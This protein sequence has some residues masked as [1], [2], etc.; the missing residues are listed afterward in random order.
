MSSDTPRSASPAP[1][2]SPAPQPTPRARS[3]RHAHL[4]VTRLDPW[5]VMKNALMLAIALGIVMLVAVALLW[6][7]LS[8]SGTLAAITRTATDIAGTGSG[9]IDLTAYL[10]FSRVMGVA[11]AITVL[12]VVLLTAMATLF[13]YLYNLSVAFTGGIQ[14]TLTEDR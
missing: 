7:M 13:A 14:M 5:S 3:I 8:M 12:E 2:V 10:S 9:S 6:A 4:F 11:A 1:G